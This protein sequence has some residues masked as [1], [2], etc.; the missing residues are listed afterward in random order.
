M[1]FKAGRLK[2]F[3][4][5]WRKLTS[6]TKILDIVMHCHITFYEGIEPERN[7]LTRPMIFSKQ[8]E[9]IIDKEI[10][11]LLAMNVIEE[12]EFLSDQYVLPIFTVP[13]KDGEYRMIL[14][15][16]DLNLSIEYYHFKMDTFETA[17]KI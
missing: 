8:E 7:T 5:E 13:K 15:L 14:N 3:E 12:V 9:N 4:N 1:Q 10:T 6:D 11:N 2:K 16:K 17:L